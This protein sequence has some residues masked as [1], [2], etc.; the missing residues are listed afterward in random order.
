M[1]LLAAV[2]AVLVVVL[3]IVAGAF[4]LVA[5]ANRL[6]AD[7][8]EARRDEAVT[9]A[10]T[11]RHAVRVLHAEL[12]TARHEAAVLRRQLT[13]QAPLTPNALDP[14]WWSTAADIHALPTTD[15]EMPR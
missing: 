15:R 6:A 10:H 13:A 1:A 9:A 14:S 12:T 11:A 7:T 2:L 5:R 8:A 3:A 4:A